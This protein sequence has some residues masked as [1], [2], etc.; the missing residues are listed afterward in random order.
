MAFCLFLLVAAALFSGLGL[1][2]VERRAWKHDLIARVDA[3]IHAPAVP[4]PG[5][6]AWPH[7]SPE[8]SE[9]LR[10]TARGR[11]VPGKVAL[12]QA[13]TALGP[14]FWLVVPFETSSGFTVLVNR[15]YVPGAWKDPAVRTNPEPA[16]EVTV[17][18]LLRLTEP[19]GGFLRANDPVGD[20]WFSRDVAAI[21]A[22][23]NLGPRAPYFIDADATL[24]PGRFPVG[25][26]TVVTFPDN[27]LVYA[28]TWFAMA[29]LCVGAAVFLWRRRI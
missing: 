22:A 5:P 18:G 11:F 19:G 10:V 17:T 21:A 14:G 26:L 27:H 15:G 9:Y 13:V 8:A 12:V 6:E 3:R 29:L 2:Q 25:G 7:I 1:W 20:R 28:L 24:P 4:A 16:G 23:R